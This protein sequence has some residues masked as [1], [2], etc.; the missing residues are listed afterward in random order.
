MDNPFAQKKASHKLS[1]KTSYK[2]IALF[3]QFSCENILA[4]STNEIE[5]QTI[6]SQPYDIWQIEFYLAEGTNLHSFKK[7]LSQFAQDKKITLIN[8]SIFF[9]DL[10]DKDWVKEYQEQQKPLEIGRFLFGSELCLA[11]SK[12]NKIPIYLG[13]SGAFGTGDHETTAGCIEAMEALSSNQYNSIFDIGT[14]S[15][16]LSFAAEKIWS[17]ASILACD[18]EKSSIEIAKTTKQLKSHLLY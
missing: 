5:S 13:A 15:G 11:T 16:I 1:F 7:Q 2:N 6:D 9:E 17:E 4:L 14:G 10:E 18:I 3:E 8:E 12:S